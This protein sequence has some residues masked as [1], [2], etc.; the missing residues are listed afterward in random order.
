MVALVNHYGTSR[1]EA[2]A[3]GK[4]EDEIRDVLLDSLV[5]LM[6]M[7]PSKGMDLTGEAVMRAGRAAVAA[8]R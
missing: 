8:R 3:D 7:I 1:K 5:Q 2:Y 4:D 6:E